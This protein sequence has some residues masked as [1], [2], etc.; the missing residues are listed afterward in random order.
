MWLL[1]SLL[2]LLFVCL[3][4]TLCFKPVKIGN[5]S[6]YS[7]LKEGELVLVDCLR[8]H[9]KNLGRGEMVAY[10][11]PVSGEILIKRVIG[12][13]GETIRAENDTIY[14]NEDFRLEENFVIAGG[15]NFSTLTIPKGSV[16]VLFD[17]RHYE[18]G[19]TN[20][21]LEFVRMEDIIGVVGLRIWPFSFFSVKAEKDTTY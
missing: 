12:L 14:I 17:N 8:I 16:F 7:T 15:L 4:F 5:M 13:G 21:G 11:D 10:R 9:L 2:A 3:L 19:I 1:S 18:N 20:R 6:M